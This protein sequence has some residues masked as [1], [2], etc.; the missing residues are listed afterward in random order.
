MGIYLTDR[1]T[2]EAAD[3]Q[4][5]LLEDL[6][7]KG[8]AGLNDIGNLI[9]GAIMIHDYSTVQVT[10]MNEWGCDKLGY[11]KDAINAMGK[12]Y[13]TRFFKPEQTENF[14]PGLLGLYG[15]KDKTET[16]S[17]FHQVKI[18]GGWDWY[19]G[20]G[21]F[22][23]RPGENDP[24]EIILIAHPISGI[25][26]MVDKVAKT[27]EE[28]EYIVKNYKKFATLTKREKEIISLLCLGKSNTD[29]SD[30]LFVSQHTIKTHRKNINKKLNIG[31]Y[32]QL[33]RFGLAF[34]LIV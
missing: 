28:N 18:N 14:V 20:V 33:I 19:L 30:Q 29:I 1:E 32:A 5:F 8:S 22:F 3:R 11:D 9:P 10:Y 6:F 12:D 27:L 17:F 31:S 26:H 2:C 7:Y 23:R 13:F 16:Y 25:G 24:G 34:D 21:K 4:L 15:R